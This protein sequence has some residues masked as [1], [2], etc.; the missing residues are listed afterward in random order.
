MEELVP[1]IATIV[2]ASTR[3]NLKV[4]TEWT[5]FIDEH[6]GAMSQ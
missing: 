4:L 1:A 3:L 5:K 6:F 2:W